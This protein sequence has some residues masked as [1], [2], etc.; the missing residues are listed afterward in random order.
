[1]GFLAFILG[2]FAGLNVHLG[3]EISRE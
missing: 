1:L 2:L 3:V